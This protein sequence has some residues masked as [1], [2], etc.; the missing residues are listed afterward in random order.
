[1]VL[2]AKNYGLFL[3][4]IERHIKV[5]ILGTERPSNTGASIRGTIILMVHKGAYKGVQIGHPYAMG[6]APQE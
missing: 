6:Y 1:M 3:E 2:C 5:S 4:Y